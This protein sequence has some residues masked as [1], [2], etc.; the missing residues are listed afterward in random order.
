MLF[1]RVLYS[2]YF[3]IFNF[4]VNWNKLLLRFIE[5]G[6]NLKKCVKKNSLCMLVKIKKHKKA[7]LTP[8]YKFTKYSV[9]LDKLV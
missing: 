8:T 9:V 5:H 7:L 3:V 2:L 6:K 1:L 4:I